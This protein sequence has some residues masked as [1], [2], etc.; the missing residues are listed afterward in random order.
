MSILQSSLL[1]TLTCGGMSSEN[2]TYFQSSATVAAGQ[3]RVRICPCDSNICQLRL[4]LDTFVISGPTTVSTSIGRTINGQM[5]N[6]RTINGGATTA[7]VQ[8]S[9]QNQCLTDTFSITSPGGNTAPVICGRNTG[10]HIYVDASDDCNDLA[11]Q[12]GNAAV[13][14]T[15]G[16]ATRQ[17]NIKVTQ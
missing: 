14:L 4:D 7:G 8:V 5:I 1:V 17:W 10:E 3:C 16:V 13:G 9:A 2:C 15:N 11:F 6:G 12:L